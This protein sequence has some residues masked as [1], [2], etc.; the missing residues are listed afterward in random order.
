[1]I[2]RSAQEANFVNC[3]PCNW[4]V[5]EVPRYEERTPCGFLIGS[6]D[7][8]I[9]N[10]SDFTDPGVVE[11]Y[12]T[13]TVIESNAYD[14][15]GGEPGYGFDDY[16]QHDER[17]D[18]YVYTRSRDLA[19]AC[20]Y[21]VTQTATFSGGYSG[22][23]DTPPAG[24]Y[25][26][27]FEY[28]GTKTA[29]GVPGTGTQTYTYAISG[30]DTDPIGE[31]FSAVSTYI[32]SS[33]MGSTWTGIYDNGSVVAEYT[34]KL[35]NEFRYGVP[36]GYDRSTYELE[37]DEVSATPEWFAWYDGGMVGAEPSPPAALVAHHSWI[38]DGISDWS[39]W[40]QMEGN[41]RVANMLITCWRSARIG[42]KPTATGPE[43]AI[44]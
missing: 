2:I 31:V 32:S 41:N 17:E 28:S 8:G 27:S 39:E 44:P 12:N 21:E 15:L 6:H 35:N 24:D 22:S 25:L 33:W 14:F 40:Y 34:G 20:I 13:V 18:I 23:Y 36:L 10:S 38:Y 29:F 37:W 26:I 30:A 19:G 43:V 9:V 42:S 5:C 4:P 16:T 11:Y 1:M 3:C 7:D